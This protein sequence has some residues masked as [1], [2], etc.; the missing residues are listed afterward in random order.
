MSWRI[1]SN[2][3]KISGILSFLI[4]KDGFHEKRWEK[5]SVSLV[6]RYFNEKRRVS[7]TDLDWPKEKKVIDV[8]Q[9]SVEHSLDLPAR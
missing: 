2:I 6:N 4:K 1:Q 8:W 9:E 3:M 7:S 5:D